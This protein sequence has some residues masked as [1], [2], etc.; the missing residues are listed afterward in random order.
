MIRAVFKKIF[1]TKNGR[2]LESFKPLV[3]QINA[4]ESSMERLSDAELAANTQLL[5][6]RIS[7]GEQL[8]DIM[9]EAFATVREASKRTLGMRHFDVQLIGGMVLHKGMIAEMRTGEGKTL[10][11]TLAAYLNALEGKGVHVVTA[12]DYLAKRDAQWMGRLYNFLGLSVG[13]VT[14]DVKEQERV[15]AYLADITY[16]TNNDFGFDYL[17]DN[18]KYD[19]SK[20]AQRDFYYAIVDEVDSILIDEART[21]LIISG[22]SQ[23]SSDLYVSIDKIVRTLGASDYVIDE[24][25]KSVVLSDLGHETLEVALKK[26][27]LIEATS[28]LYNIK[29]MNVLHHAQQALKAHKV[30]HRDVDYMVQ[31]AQVM[32]IDEFTGRVMEGRRYSEGLHQ[33]LEAKEGVDIQNENQTLASVTFQN[34]FRMYPKLAGMTGTAMTEA[35]EFSSIYNLAVVAIP[36]NIEPKRVDMDDEIYLGAMEKYRAMIKDIQEAH[37]KGQ[38]ILIGTTSIEKSELISQLLKNANIKHN[39]LNAKYHEQE[40]LI[41]A[42]AGRLKAVTIATNMAGRGTDIVLGGNAE[43]LLSGTLTKDKLEQMK[44]KINH[45]VAQ[46]KQQ[47]LAVGGLYVVGTERH[48]SRRIDNQLRGRAGRQGDPGKTKFYLSME[49]DLMRMFGSDKIRG[50]LAKLGVAEGEAI[51]HPWVSRSIAKAQSKVEMRNYDMRKTLLRFDDVMNQQRKV[52]YEH[53]KYVLTTPH[54]LELALEQVHDF[55]SDI[56]AKYIPKDSLLDEWDFEG[57]SQNLQYL[58]GLKFDAD[59]IKNIGAAEEIEQTLLQMAKG[60]L[61][62]KQHQYGEKL[63]D[64]ALRYVMIVT[65]DSLWQNHLNA[66][67]H[68]RTGIGLRAYAQK[69]PLNEYKFEA[70]TMF[71]DMLRECD[72]LAAQRIMNLQV[73]GEVE[74]IQE[75]QGILETRSLEGTLNSKPQLRAKQQYVEP[76]KRDPLD[77]STWGKVLRNE[78]CPCGSGKKYKHCHGVL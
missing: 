46:E 11:A 72:T 33:A 28:E 43:M 50:L 31:G 61:I 34:Y 12:N 2:M 42:Q 75:R 21:P 1:G 15:N 64:D 29:N 27:R 41:I 67:D 76:N 30:F 5:K 53:R 25:S 3:Q 37:A 52:V 8:D 17:R 78:L 56:V 66:L 49:D 57:L 44:A 18:L 38:P 68:L 13:C 77:E 24:K 20:T 39:V 4:L 7:R 69:D 70:F 32:I 74:T 63:F 26:A 59:Y 9:V 6:H 14:H 45:E 73:Q 60:L 62:A 47:V 19:L 10:V 23:D 51:V 35:V 40:A 48:E 55:V 58:L 71:K 54:L 16:G 65:L 36:P 22:P